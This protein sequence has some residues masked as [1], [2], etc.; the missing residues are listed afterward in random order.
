MNLKIDIDIKEIFFKTITYL[1]KH[2]DQA[3]VVSILVIVTIAA[4]LSSFLFYRF[5]LN[6][7]ELTDGEI[8]HKNIKIRAQDEIFEKIKADKEID[9]SEK[10]KLDKI[11]RD[12]FK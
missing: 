5:A 7:K 6:P 1:K 11:T 10:N 2:T 3:V 8:N 12:P 4:L 9:A